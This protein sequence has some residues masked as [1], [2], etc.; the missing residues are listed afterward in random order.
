MGVY[1]NK[2]EL[3]KFKKNVWHYTYVRINHHEKVMKK[4]NMAIFEYGSFHV[5]V[6]KAK[7]AALFADLALIN[8]TDCFNDRVFLRKKILQ[9]LEETN[10]EY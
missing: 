1:Y 8:E 5:S 3:E 7:S 2:T 10:I 6:P 9:A 4:F